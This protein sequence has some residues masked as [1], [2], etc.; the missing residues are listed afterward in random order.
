MAT[1]IAI[2][3]VGK[4]RCKDP[5]RGVSGKIGVV[6]PANATVTNKFIE[7]LDN[8]SQGWKPDVPNI[9]IAAEEGIDPVAQDLVTGYSFEN[10]DENLS[11]MIRVVVQHTGE[12]QG[13]R[14]AQFSI[15]NAFGC[16]HMVTHPNLVGGIVTNE[17]VGIKKVGWI[18]R[19]DESTSW[20]LPIQQFDVSPWTASQEPTFSPEAYSW[21]IGFT[22]THP[23]KA[24]MVRLALT[25]CRE[26]G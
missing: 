16:N 1:S 6:L 12:F 11:R 20:G 3:S 10:R 25:L 5:K 14:I 8:D 18:A 7:F 17:G 9:P 26:I 4:L 22:N 24:R 2:L 19:D 13:S 23:T 21:K 15:V